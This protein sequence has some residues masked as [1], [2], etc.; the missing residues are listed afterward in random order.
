M[1]TTAPV[2]TALGTKPALSKAPKQFLGGRIGPIYAARR[3][4]VGLS[5]RRPRVRFPPGAPLLCLGT[6]E[7]DVSGHSRQFRSVRS[8]GSRA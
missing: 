5:N 6:S 7:T 2:G 3:A 8:A 1:G 4:S